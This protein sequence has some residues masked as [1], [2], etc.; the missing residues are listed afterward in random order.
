[1][2]ILNKRQNRWKQHRWGF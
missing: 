2:L 1:M